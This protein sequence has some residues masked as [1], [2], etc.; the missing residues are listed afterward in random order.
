MLTSVVVPV[1]VSTRWCQKVR[2]YRNTRNC[3]LEQVTTNGEQAFNTGMSYFACPSVETDK[4][5]STRAEK[6]AW[7]FPNLYIHVMSSILIPLYFDHRAKPVFPFGGPHQSICGVTSHVG[8]GDVLS[9]T[10]KNVSS[11]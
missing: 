11:K 5:P 8:I 2:D 7:R 1:V 10:H 3:D 6:E 9:E 4:R